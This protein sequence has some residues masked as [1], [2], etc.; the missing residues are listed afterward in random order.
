MILKRNN[1][2]YIDGANLH[3]GSHSLG[4]ELDYARFRIWMKEN[5]SITHAYIFLGYVPRYAEKYASLRDAGFILV[6]K[7]TVIGANKQVKG[8][9]D[10]DLVLR[11]VCDTYEDDYDEAIIVS[12]DGD[13]TCLVRFLNKKKRFRAIISPHAR[14]SILLRQM[15][16]P[17]TY[18]NDIRRLVQKRL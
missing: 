13:Y 4:W 9:C 11:A 14:C 16:L 3:R 1:R 10:A 17:V 8:N 7:E 5:H 2:A 6:F 12:S 18:L 15:N